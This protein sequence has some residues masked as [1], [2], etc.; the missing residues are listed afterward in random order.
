ML[1]RSKRINVFGEAPVFVSRLL[2][3]TWFHTAP[4]RANDGPGLNF[5][6]WEVDVWWRYRLGSLTAIERWRRGPTGPA[7]N[8]PSSTAT[9]TAKW[10][11]PRAPAAKHRPNRGICRATAGVLSEFRTKLGTL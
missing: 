10:S 8:G 1:M 7:K 6:H 9:N 11:S 4:V 5:V 3:G 2:P